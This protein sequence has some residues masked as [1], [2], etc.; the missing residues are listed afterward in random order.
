MSLATRLEPGL[1]C[2]RDFS[3][4]LVAAQIGKDVNTAALWGFFFLLI[5]VTQ[6]SASSLA[7]II[8][9]L[10]EISHDILIFR[11]YEWIF[12]AN[13]DLED[14][15]VTA[16]IDMIKFWA[17]MIKHIRRTPT[18]RLMLSI[19]FRDSLKTTRQQL[20]K[21]TERI[22]ARAQALALRQRSQVE[23][24]AQLEKL[25]QLRLDSEGAPSLPASS[26]EEN[27]S[28]DLPFTNLTIPRNPNFVGRVEVLQSLRQALDHVSGQPQ[29]RS[30]T[31]HGMPGVGKTS[32]A[33]EYAHTQIQQGVEVVLWIN[34]ERAI[35][36]DL[37]FSSIA[38]SMGLTGADQNGDHLKNRQLVMKWLQRTKHDWLVVFDN[39]E[40]PTLLNVCWPSGPHGS[41]LVTS[42]NDMPHGPNEGTT[43]IDPFTATEGLEYL[44][45][46]IS[47]KTYDKE[48]RDSALSLCQEP[49]VAGYPLHLNILGAKIRGL[50]KSISRYLNQ[51]RQNPGGTLKQSARI[52]NPQY[53][54]SVATVW[55]E[56]FS[57]FEREDNSEDVLSLLGVLSCVAA[58]DIPASFFVPGLEEGTPSLNFCSDEETFDEALL[59][60]LNF[61]VVQRDG[62]TG[63]LSLHRVAQERFLEWL[64]RDKAFET[65]RSAAKIVNAAFPKQAKGM[66]LRN[67]WRACNI[68]VSH[69]LALSA[70]YRK[71]RWAP[72]FPGDYE[73]FIDLIKSCGWFL[74][75]RGSWREFKDLF[76][77]AEMVCDD[78]ESLAW[79]HILNTASLVES[80]RGHAAQARPLIE[81]ALEIRQRCLPPD[82]MDLSDAYNNFGFMLLVESPDAN[83][84]REAARY[85]DMARQ[86]DEKNPNGSKVLHV[87][88]LN[89]GKAHVI[90]GDYAE[91]ERLYEIGRE[92]SEK[93]YGKG[94]HFVGRYCYLLGDLRLRQRKY[95]EA[96]PLLERCIE[97]QVKENQTHP[98]VS[99][100]RMKLAS[101]A[102]ATGRVEQAMFIG[103]GSCQGNLRVECRRE[104]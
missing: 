81:R 33:V 31:L 10:D 55:S 71:H 100:T 74:M 38:A 29:L 9:M 79:A 62:D 40:N 37:S 85:F 61:S 48:E 90:L 57:N 30:W 77:T 73:T 21:Q 72:V 52:T 4:I 46:I 50:N 35:D 64:G 103:A 89:M 66:G 102:M 16:M 19:T 93:T 88:Y 28:A 83:T 39:V 18:V 91:G 104:G 70:C 86:L 32:V 78:K 26:T 68:A 63:S 17:Q 11:E 34:S 82:D 69:V 96:K 84:M 42:R 58:Q 5:E 43:R 65:F 53:P 3:A 25:E 41:I 49:E 98:I 95:D 87:R 20:Q 13:P 24:W 56:A 6:K 47:R 23:T 36:F 2:L 22:K 60:L 27:M 45:R 67:E 75:E 51:F 7:E 76:V 8:D 59:P 14:A 101:I 15:L 92:Y 1:N 44:L 94:T 80:E 99:A 54:K 12:V 97:I